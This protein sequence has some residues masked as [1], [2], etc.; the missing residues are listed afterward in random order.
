MIDF[1]K[2]YQL[3]THIYNTSDRKIEIPDSNIVICNCAYTSG[4]PAEYRSNGV[5]KGNLYYFE[6][7][8]DG[9]YENRHF[10]YPI[11]MPRREGKFS[12]GIL[13]FHGL[14]ERS[15]DKYLVW[16]KY[17]AEK[18]DRPVIMFPIAYHI[19]RC[20]KRW[21]DPRSMTEVA[22]DR[23][24]EEV[25]STFANAALSTR[26][27]KNPEK[28]L[29]SG[30]QS[31]Y[32]VI[33]LASE[34]KDGRNEF[35]EKGAHIDIFSYSIG[36]FLSEIL[37]LNNFNDIF[38]DLRLFMFCG[39]TTFDSMN[40]ISKYIMDE[41]A[42]A[43]LMTLNDPKKL[44]QIGRNFVGATKSMRFLRNWNGIGL[45]MS[46]R[47]RR[48]ERE[49]L[50]E[51]CAYNIYAIALERDTVMPPKKIVRTLKGKNGDIPTRVEIIDFPYAYSHESPFPITDDKIQPLVNRCFSLVFNNVANFFLT[52]DTVRAKAERIRED[53]AQKAVQAEREVARKAA[54]EEA[55]RRA[56]KESKAERRNAK[57][58]AKAAR[59]AAATERK[60]PK[61]AD[62]AAR[63]AA[64]TERKQQKAADKAARKAAA[65]ER[66]Q[67]KAEVAA[68]R[69]AKKFD[70]KHAS[71]EVSERRTE[72]ESKAALKNAKAT[73]KAARRAAATE[74]KQQKAAAKAARKATAIERK[75]RKAEAKAVR[76]TDKAAFKAAREAEKAKKAEQKRQKAAEKA[77]RAAQ[78]RQKAAFSAFAKVCAAEHDK[79]KASAEAV[80][81]TRKNDTKQAVEARTERR[82]KQVATAK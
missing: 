50:L 14:N 16:A 62:K 27:E 7:A 3:L 69:K 51:K 59:R 35:F 61:A 19:N 37:M 29:V 76:R 52:G 70:V 71:A 53:K 5:P 20:P 81:K 42:Y 41:K 32:D 73:A 4:F 47:K 8:Q 40:G 55:K 12:S 28:F 11:M 13:F 75:Q 39:G 21:S 43:S 9:D 24:S 25:S 68:T 6:L 18:C 45:M 63:R 82:K 33:D 67:R 1:K 44:R 80:H 58:A 64:A 60:Q 2:E 48:R 46:S 74:R 54:E 15:W 66:K 49:K 23:S 38:R 56:E 22:K 57:A 79:Y 26:L 10:I 78:K 65:I 72:K 30:I 17:L 34:I 36:A 77:A 31:Y